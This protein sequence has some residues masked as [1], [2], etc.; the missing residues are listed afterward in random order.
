[1]TTT[2]SPTTVRPLYEIAREITAKWRPVHF[3][4]SPYLRAM[5]S[6]T[7]LED[8]YG[9]GDEPARGIVLYFLSNARTWRGED[10]RRI[11]AEL[12]GMLK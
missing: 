7:T 9:P 10:A 12:K 4:A 1:M 6:M 2:T 5:R 3:A 11:K 8:T